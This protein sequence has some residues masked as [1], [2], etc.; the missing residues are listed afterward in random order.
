MTVKPVVAFYDFWIGFYWDP[1]ER[2]LFIL[3]LPMFGIC[4]QFGSI[5]P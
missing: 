3:P 2:R 1:A 5:R 4:I